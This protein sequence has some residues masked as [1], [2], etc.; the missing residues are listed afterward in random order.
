MENL[1][2]RKPVVAILLSFITP[3]LGQM[4]NGRLR[5][6]VILY[7]FGFLLATVLLFSGLFLKFYGMILCLAILLSFFLFILLDALIGAVKSK[8]ITLK[9]YNKWYFYLII[10]LVSTFVIQPFVSS[11]IKN[12]IVRAYE[13]PSSAMKPTLLV[14]DHLIANMGIYKKE[15]P[16]RGDIVIFEYPKDPSKDFIKRVIG[17]EGEKVE[18]I[19]NKI[20]INDKLLDDPWGYYGEGRVTKYLQ[21]LDNFGPVVVPKDSLFV[22][23]DNRDNS[24]DSRFWGYVNIKKLKG[25]ALYI[26][27]AKNKS[28]IGIQIK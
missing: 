12:N 11:S 24:Q 3:G 9:P 14:G 16:K 8:E 2:R 17:L 15:K 20:Y 23:G 19:Q 25:K 5:R 28:R 26:Y 6:G 7:L 13:I 10:F 22:L 1:R 27:W 21:G 18:M 4:Y